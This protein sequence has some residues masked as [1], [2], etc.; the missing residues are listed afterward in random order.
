MP[1]GVIQKEKD[2]HV[3][4]VHF[5]QN[6]VCYLFIYLESP[7]GI[8]LFKLKKKL[9]R[10]FKLKNYLINFQ[11]VKYLKLL[12]IKLII[13]NFHMRVMTYPVAEP[14]EKGLWLVSLDI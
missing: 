13:A 12:I 11:F 4:L 5:T 3:I 9:Q 7:I 1:A 10:N 6:R 14:T 8:V 2:L